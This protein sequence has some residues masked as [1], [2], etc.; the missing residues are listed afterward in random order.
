MS[1]QNALQPAVVVVGA[2]RGIGRAMAKVAARDR[3]TVV[4]VARS[5]EALAA[6]AT[7]VR[8]AGGVALSLELD[9]VGA[10]ASAHLEN[11]LSAN[12]LYCDRSYRV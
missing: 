6:A 4:L 12:G 10:S 5:P 3:S 9:L 11:F 8:D 7:D 2:S 1:D